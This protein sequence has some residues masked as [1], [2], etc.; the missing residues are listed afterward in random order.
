MK[1]FHGYNATLTS[2][3]NKLKTSFTIFSDQCSQKLAIEVVL[4]INVYPSDPVILCG[5]TCLNMN[6]YTF[7]IAGKSLDSV[8]DRKLC[9]FYIAAHNIT[10]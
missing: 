10:V 2:L 8:R 9:T 7:C 1:H 6:T 5:L 3:V 4:N